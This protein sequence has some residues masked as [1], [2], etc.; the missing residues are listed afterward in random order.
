MQAETPLLLPGMMCDSRLFAPQQAYFRDDITIIIPAIPNRPSL[1]EMA[2]IILADA[3]T[4]FAL[5][6]L[7]MGGIL[8]MEIMAQASH[9]VSH[10]ALFNTNPFA[11]RSETRHARIPQ[12]DK[13]ANGGLEALMRD[14]IIPRYFSA[15]A[16][17][18]HLSTLCLTMALGCG[19]EAFLTQS[20][21]LRDRADYSDLLRSVRCPAAIIG[22]EDDI[23]C[24]PERHHAIADLM[25]HASLHILAKTGHLSTLEQPDDVNQILSDLLIIS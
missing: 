5:G 11:E 24:P 22:A 13:V 6:G 25:P 17:K 12:M 14:E 16:D 8:A 19:A 4:S 9:R 1:A 7:S 23:I 15:Q 3:P 2:E 21:A 20:I 18:E 10:L